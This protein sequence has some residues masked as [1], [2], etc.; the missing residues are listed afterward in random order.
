MEELRVKELELKKMEKVNKK[1]T[2]M[3]N[4]AAVC[5]RVFY[6]V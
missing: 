4:V 1:L 2:G 5:T 3:V 6:M